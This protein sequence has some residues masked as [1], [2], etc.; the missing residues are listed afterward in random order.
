MV[1]IDIIFDSLGLICGWA[2]ALLWM[3]LNYL[4]KTVIDIESISIMIYG[5]LS[6]WWQFI[7]VSHVIDQFGIK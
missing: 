3:I 1:I 2:S 4:A 7:N 6:V 5:V